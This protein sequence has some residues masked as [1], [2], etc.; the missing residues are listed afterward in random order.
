MS[1]DSESHGTETTTFEH[2]GREW[3]VPTRQH[4]RQAR[5]MKAVLRQFGELDADDVAEI[6]LSKEDYQALL[7]LDVPTEELDPFST[8]IA[9]A[10]GMRETGNSS[11]SPA[12]S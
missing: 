7:E 1:L 11:P 10:L 6:F 3:T 2:F 12:S 8:K 5:Q 9:Q 4:H